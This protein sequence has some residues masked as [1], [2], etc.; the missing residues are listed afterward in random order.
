ML[1]SFDCYLMHVEWFGNSDT[2]RFEMFF[3]AG[4]KASFPMSEGRLHLT[5]SWQQTNLLHKLDVYLCMLKLYCLWKLIQQT[6][7][8][9]MTRHAKAIVLLLK[10]YTTDASMYN[11]SYVLYHLRCYTSSD[12]FRN[13]VLNKNSC[14]F[15]CMASSTTYIVGIF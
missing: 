15:I 13:P 9:T 1:P 4:S 7:Q 6:I 5:Q 12:A 2:A 11:V 10:T 3:M 8:C 14:E